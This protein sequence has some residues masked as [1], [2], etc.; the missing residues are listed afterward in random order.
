MD[1]E[2]RSYC[3]RCKIWVGSDDTHKCPTE[4]LVVADKEMVGIV[5]RLYQMGITPMVV[6]WSTTELGE[7]NDYEYLITLKIDIGRKISEAI[8]GDL[9]SDWQYHWNTVT[10]DRLEL[11]MIAYVE[12]WH[13]L[14]FESLDERINEL[15][16]GFEAFLDTRDSEAVKAL[17]LLMEV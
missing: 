1:I 8:L 3:M 11:H 17:L 14:G 16:K 5:D 9:P 13:N 15:I 6:V 4:H 7:T 2:F 10:P 12:R